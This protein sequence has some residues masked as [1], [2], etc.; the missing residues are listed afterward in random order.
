M[1][2]A[3]LFQHGY[4]LRETGVLAGDDRSSAAPVRAVWSK[5]ESIGG[6][7]PPLPHAGDV[8]HDLPPEHDSRAGTSRHPEKIVPAHGVEPASPDDRQREE[9][10]SDDLRL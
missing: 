3:D 6:S 2:Q 10:L 1:P 7:L 4:D 9:L 8:C 5:Q